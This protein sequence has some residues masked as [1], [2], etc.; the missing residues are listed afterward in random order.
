[1]RSV[2]L[3]RTFGIATLAI[4][5]LGAFAPARSAPDARFH[6]KLLKSSPADKD[7]VVNGPAAIKLWFSESIELPVSSVK[8]TGPKGEPIP[9][10]K[11]THSDSANAPVVAG[12]TKPLADGAYKVTWKAASKDGHPATG[13]V[14]FTVRIKR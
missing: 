11:L 1:M 13:T 6:I 8:L 5:A 12:I 7:T 9:L 14:M 2:R 3:G 10:A 4:F